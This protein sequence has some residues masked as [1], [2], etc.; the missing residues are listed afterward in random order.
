MFAGCKDLPS[1]PRI[2]RGLIYVVSTE[3]AERWSTGL[4]GVGMHSVCVSIKG[5]QC[6]CLRVES[7][8]EELGGHPGGTVSGGSR[9]EAQEGVYEAEGIKMGH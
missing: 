1:Y 7:P 2:L 4:G 9:E 3:R 6:W 5:F 8:Q